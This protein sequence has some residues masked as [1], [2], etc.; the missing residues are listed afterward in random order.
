MEPKCSSD[1]EIQVQELHASEKTYSHFTALIDDW[2]LSSNK[3]NPRNWTTCE[4]ICLSVSRAGADTNAVKK[5]YHVVPVAL[6]CLCVTAGSSIITPGTIAIQHEF[7]VSQTASLLPLSL[8]VL[9]LGIGPMIA[10][11]ISETHGRAIVYKLSMPLYM[12][13]ILGAGFSKSFAGLLI[14][15]TLAAMAG[16][17]CL[18]IRAGTVA[19]LFEPS[20]RAA[21]NTFVVMA[22]FLGPCK[23]LAARIVA[24][25]LTIVLGLGP[26][27]GG[28]GATFTDYRWTQWSTI[29]L[30][31]VGYLL[32]LPTQET[33]QEVLLERK[34][35][36]IGIPHP[37][38]LPTYETV[39]LMFTI[40]LV[41]P[42]RMLF[43]EPIVLL[44]SIYN[45]FTFSVLFAFFEAYPFVFMGQY[46]FNLWQCGLTFSGIGVGVLL[47]A[48]AAILVDR[49]VYQRLLQNGDERIKTKRPEQRLYNG[50][51]GDLCIPIG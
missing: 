28:F 13:F 27:I 19:D 35:R 39:K 48:I 31:L 37:E 17:P 10:A 23:P 24:Q 22:G 50:M 44:Y 5:T 25:A 45:A 34:A 1:T 29:F 8:Y 36:R 26:V 16:A 42:F 33:H 15:R 41:R 20:K 4:L 49:I 11:P 18:A 2:S 9:G 14:C 46:G 43:T 7:H 47:G 38:Q 32:L 6:L 51:I 40:T 3:E 12:L 30:A 21:P